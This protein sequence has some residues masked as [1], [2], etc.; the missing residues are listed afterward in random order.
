MAETSET[1]APTPIEGDGDRLLEDDVVVVPTNDPDIAAQPE[2]FEELRILVGIMFGKSAQHR[3]YAIVQTVPNGGFPP[4]G[5]A[6]PVNEVPY[7]AVLAGSTVTDGRLAFVATRSKDDGVDFIIQHEG[8][9]LGGP[10]HPDTP[11]PEWNPPIDLGLPKKA[12]FKQLQLGLNAA[13]LLSVNGLDEKGDVWW[14]FQNPPVKVEKE[15]TITPPGSDTP[16]T[17]KVFVI[18]PADPPFGVWQK[19]PGVVASK[20]VLTN[21]PDGRIILLGLTDAGGKSNL[22]RNEQRTAAATHPSDWTGWQTVAP[23]AI[24]PF[25]DVAVSIDSNNVVNAFVVD[26]DR[27]I[28]HTK[29]DP[30]GSQTWTPYFRPGLPQAELESVAA[31]LDGDGDIAL[32]AVDTNGA[33]W[34]IQQK[35]AKTAQWTSWQP[36][37]EVDPPS[38]IDFQYNADG[39]LTLFGLTP[40]TKG[41]DGLLWSVDQAALDST[42]WSASIA[43]H[44]SDGVVYTVLRDLRLARS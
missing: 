2:F 40:D 29:Q 15:I 11:G 13:G 16:I 24:T 25:T 35:S 30:A 21:N 9:S 5:S 43:R 17:T 3:L 22:V 27:K 32:A 1:I 33:V 20:I 26:G 7:N 42:E 19:L 38:A 6:E 41:S 36:I 18:E 23:G 8:R 39:R 28:S 31:G 10:T 4:P 34:S 37:I 12:K 14:L 44:G